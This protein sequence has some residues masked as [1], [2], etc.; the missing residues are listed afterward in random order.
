MARLDRYSIKCLYE[1]RSGR[2]SHTNDLDVWGVGFDT[3]SGRLFIY[4][5][6]Y[7]GLF[8]Q[9]WEGEIHQMTGTCQFTGTT[10]QAVKRY[11]DM[12]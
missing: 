1:D 3:S 6:P 4:S 2:C 11:M 10:S 7:G 8:C 5:T 9:D 12:G